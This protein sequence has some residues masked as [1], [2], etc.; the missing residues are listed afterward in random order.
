[1][2]LKRKIFSCSLFR[3]IFSNSRKERFFTDLIKEKVNILAGNIDEFESLLEIDDPLQL[4]D[5][6]LDLVDLSLLTVGRVDFT[7]VGT[8]IEKKKKKT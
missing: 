3:D 7:L 2:L 4:L 5:K 8:V 6:S 1:M